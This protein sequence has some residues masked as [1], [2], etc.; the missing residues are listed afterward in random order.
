MLI[1][2]FIE[3]HCSL[4]PNTKL[5][6]QG[7]TELNF[8]EGLEQ[9]Y[10]IA[11]GLK[12]LGLSKG[13]RVAI[14][15]ENS[16]DHILLCFAASLV[17]AVTA[18]L[19]YRLAAAE[20]AAI[21]NDAEADLLIVNDET[22]LDALDG[23]RSNLPE[24]IQVLTCA[25]NNEE[26]QSWQDFVAS[27]SPDPVASV[28]NEDDC[29]LQLYTSGTTG[30]PKGVQLSHKN[31]I[32]MA[33]GSWLM[34]R[35]PATVGT[36][37]LVVAPLF[38]IGGMGS[39]MV[40]LLAGAT[41]ILHKQFDPV[42]I[43]DDIERLGVNNIFMVPAM[44]QAIL[45]T[46]PDIQKRDFS[47]LNQVLYGASPISP[48]LLREAMD[49]F[50]CD[51][52]QAY[53]MTETTGGVVFLT[54]EDH[55]RALDGEPDLLQSCGRISF[56][57]SVKIVDSNGKNLPNG[58]TGEIAIRSDLN[59]AGYWKREEQTKQAV[60]D[61]WVHTGDAGYIDDEGYIFI[62]DRIKDMVVTGGENVYPVEVEK[63][64]AGHPAV[65]EAAVIGVPDEKYGEA[66]LAICGLHDGQTLTA[67]ELI[68]YCRDKIAG[69]KIPR[70]LAIVD[71][72]PRNPSGKILKTVL[73]EPYWPKGGKQV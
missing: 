7:S 11:N 22:M 69:Y 6:I 41:A 45:A 3:Y 64:L 44:I 23:M 5:L 65:L 39:A 28:A 54:G 1:N 73:R 58:V 12:T 42:A 27:Q 31:L 43:A 60:R 36:I 38:H 17:G 14:L 35:H 25:C 15:G 72:L 2:Q 18:P 29:I 63:V 70:Q 34:Y 67:E 16:I 46:V 68:E 26:Q 19:N 61:G 20:L 21:V 62:R 71:A 55:Q 47:Q 13:S 48:S 10:R 9:I 4:R 66:L 51:F 52:Y 33:Q 57:S 40:P 8:K 59:T 30:L 32:R 53:G 50:G 49:V 37:D 24:N 56:G